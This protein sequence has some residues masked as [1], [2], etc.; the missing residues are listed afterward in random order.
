ML[1][2]NLFSQLMVS[3]GAW[4]LKKENEQFLK[5]SLT[6]SLLSSPLLDSESFLI[7]DQNIRILTMIFLIRKTAVMVAKGMKHC[8]GS[9]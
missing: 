9:A 6:W 7:I 1:A 3:Y 8:K 4:Y 2:T 5:A